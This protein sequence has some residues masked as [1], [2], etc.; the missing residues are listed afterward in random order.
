ME[1]VTHHGI[2]YVVPPLK[3]MRIFRLLFSVQKPRKP[4]TH[5]TTMYIY[6]PIRS[7]SQETLIVGQALNLHVMQGVSDSNFSKSLINF[8]ELPISYV[9]SRT[10]RSA[11][12]IECNDAPPGEGP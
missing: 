1:E 10:V 11:R 9:L 4:A 6:Q 5:T 3:A 2:L 12:Y 8:Y 7:T